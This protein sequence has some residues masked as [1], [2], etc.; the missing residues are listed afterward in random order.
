MLQRL[1]EVG[2]VDRLDRVQDDV[3]RQQPLDPPARGLATAS[4]GARR[5][6]RRERRHDERQ[7]ARGDDEVQRH[8]QVRR[9]AARPGS[10]SGT[11][12]RATASAPSSARPAV[13]SRP[14]RPPTTGEH[15]GRRRP[16]RTAGGGARSDAAAANARCRPAAAPAR[17]PARPASRSRGSG[18][19]GPA[20]APA[21]SSAMTR[22]RPAF[23][24]GPVSA[25]ITVMAGEGTRTAPV[26][27]STLSTHV[28]REARGRMRIRRAGAVGVWL[29]RQAGRRQPRRRHQSR[30]PRQDR[31]SAH[32][33]EQ[34]PRVYPSRTR[35][36]VAEVGNTDLQIGAPPGG[37]LRSTS[38]RPP[39][40]AQGAQIAGTVQGAEVI[41]SALA[42]SEPGAR[43]P[44]SRRSRPVLPRE[45]RG[46]RQALRGWH[47]H[48]LIAVLRIDGRAGSDGRSRR[49]R[50]ATGR[51]SPARRV[52]AA[53]GRRRRPAARACRP[54]RP[55]PPR[56]P[57]PPRRVRRRSCSVSES[58]SGCRGPRRRPHC[59]EQIRHGEVGAVILFAG[60][61]RLDAT[62][63]IPHRRA[64]ARRARGTQPAAADRRRPGGRAG[65]AAAERAAVAVAAADRRHRERQR[66]RHAGPRHRPLPRAARD[67]HG[68][69]AGR[70]RAHVHG[71]VRL[72]AGARVLVQRRRR[73]RNT[74]LRSRSDSS[75]AASPRPP[76]T[77][78]AS[79]P[80]PIDTDNKLQVLHPSAGPARRGARRPTAR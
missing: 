30:H 63:R 66:R 71:R 54:S 1:L 49:T 77:S 61:H 4:C 14:R 79:E 34:P 7:R 62:A 78:P 59:C 24:S 64:A 37:P 36:Q 50:S 72:A 20:G 46:S 58:W 9:R 43:T 48:A 22:P 13:R 76:S 28:L 25:A 21:A 29:R 26:R 47:A 73:R 65:Q 11:A 23:G 3:Q 27:S 60:E 16:P 67:Q 70:R 42:V 38:S 51:A 41:G 19:R 15:H 75:R 32:D 10:G 68:P 31:R 33:Q 39:A 17:A 5:P 6:P 53:G 52:I 45:S 8:E 12:A 2:R 55:R 69:R 56:P 35:L 44:S 40:Q 57:C 18:A 74:A 80:Q